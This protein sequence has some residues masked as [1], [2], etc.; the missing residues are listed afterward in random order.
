MIIDIPEH[1][2]QIWIYLAVFG[3][4]FDPSDLTNAIGIQSTRAY[5][6]G[7]IAPLEKGIS[8]KPGSPPRNGEEKKMFGSMA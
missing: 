8:S 7:D 6:K 5:R 1:R 2:N 4:D 3:D